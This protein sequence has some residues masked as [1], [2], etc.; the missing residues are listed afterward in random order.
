MFSSFNVNVGIVRYLLLQL[1]KRNAK[2]TL[3]LH[4]LVSLILK[5]QK[6]PKI[7]EERVGCLIFVVK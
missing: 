4:I 2:L 1:N 5:R 6:E 7:W 3:I